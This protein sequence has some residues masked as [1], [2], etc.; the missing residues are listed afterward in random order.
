MCFWGIAGKN[1]SE[2]HGFIWLH[3]LFSSTSFVRALLAVS[4]S[5]GFGKALARVQKVSI[6]EDFKW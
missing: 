5:C 2:K 6:F 3:L 1:P 4:A